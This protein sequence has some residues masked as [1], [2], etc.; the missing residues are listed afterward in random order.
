VASVARGNEGWPRSAA[1]QGMAGSFGRH[2]GVAARR[3]ARVAACASTGPRCRLD[4]RGGEGQR[5]RGA[6]ALE[7]GLMARPSKGAARRQ[8]GSERGGAAAQRARVL[9]GSA[10][11]TQGGGKGREKESRERKREANVL[12]RDFL[13]IFHGNSKKFENESCSKF[14]FLQLFFQA[15]I[16]LSNDLKVKNLKSSLNEKPPNPLFFVVFSKFHV[17]T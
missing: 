10:A 8:Q 7:R 14:K 4:G 12:T 1:R 16:H 13:K 5:A 11:R 6:C 15:K 17:V 2:G 9:E 3:R